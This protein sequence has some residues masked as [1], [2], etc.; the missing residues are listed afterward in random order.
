MGFAD[1][2]R[3]LARLEDDGKWLRAAC[4]RRLDPVMLGVARLLARGA[5]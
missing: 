4:R 1:L 5:K 2:L 3:Q